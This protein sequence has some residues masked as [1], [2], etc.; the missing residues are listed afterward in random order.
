VQYR[1]ATVLDWPAIAAFLRDTNYFIPQDLTTIGGHWLI[2]TTDDGVVHGTL[3]Y[4]AEPPQAFV[5]FWAA[6]GPRTAA[7]LGVLFERAM[8]TLG[9]RYAHGMIFCSNSD[10]TRLAT[11]GLGMIAAGSYNRVFKDMGRNQ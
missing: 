1:F 4:F 2:A 5:D 6:K 3:W 11:D 8:R 7:R 10:A 9:A